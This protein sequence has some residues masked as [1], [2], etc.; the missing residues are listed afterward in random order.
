MATLPGPV[1][2]RMGAGEQEPGRES[3]EQAHTRTILRTFS[4]A[5]KEV[6]AG[7]FLAFNPTFGHRKDNIVSPDDDCPINVVLLLD[8]MKYCRWLSDRE[9]ISED[10]MC[11]PPLG[12]IKPG[13]KPNP[14]YLSRT[15]YRLPTEAEMEYA[16]RAG[17][18]SS[19]SFGDDP[20]LLP[21]YAWFTKNSDS[22][23]WPPGRLLPNDYGLFDILGNVREWCQD[24]YRPRGDGPDLGRPGRR[25]SEGLPRYPGRLL[26]RSC[27]GPPLGQPL[28]HGAR[29]PEQRDGLPDRADRF[30]DRGETGPDRRRR[31]YMKRFRTRSSPSKNDQAGDRRVPI[32]IPR[33]PPRN[34]S[35]G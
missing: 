13:V 5:T 35:R 19:R 27:P 25:E 1:T 6:T 32:A 10:Q 20:E 4:I 16:C 22:R 31:S 15:G 11:Y 34:P 18:V 2:F 24:T 23:T 30:G 29:L 9:Q 3:D 17:A 12:D 21:R 8:A 26:C 14:G 33:R 7:Q 28:L